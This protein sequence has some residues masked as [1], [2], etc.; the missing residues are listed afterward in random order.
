MI[1]SRNKKHVCEAFMRCS[2]IFSLILLFAIARGGTVNT[3]LAQETVR[4]ISVK[5]ENTSV[6]NALREIN[7]LSGNQVV[8]RTEEVAKETKRVTFESQNTP[9]I[10]V[11][12]KCL[13]GT[14]LN[15]TLREGRIIVV[16]Q[17][18]KD[19]QI[20]G[21]VQ[22]ES[23]QPLPGVTVLL[24]GTTLGTA[25]DTDGKYKLTLPSNTPNPALV[26]SFIGMKTQ[27]IAYSGQNKVNVT[28]AQEASEIDE[29]VVTGIFQK[30]KESYTGAATT[31]TADDLK[32]VGNRNI[33][34]SIRNI[35]PSF[36]IIDNPMM[37]SDPNALPDITIRGNAS[38]TT[39]LNDLQSDSRTTQSAN[40]PLFIMDGFE[41][42][43]ERMMDLDDNQIETI[44]LLKDASATAMY[45]TRGANGVVV[46]TTKQ[47]EE[48]KLRLTYKGGVDL[49][50]PDLSSYNLMNAKE[51]LAYEKAAGVYEYRMG[52]G[53]IDGG[54]TGQ[55]LQDLYNIR[56]LAAE[57]GVDT[58][59]LKYPVR[60]GVGHNHSLRL[61]G[62][63]EEIRYAVG[64]QYKNVAGA[65]K[66]S[67]R[68][69]FNGN[70]FL[71]YKLKN[72]TF[73]NDLQISH[74]K[75]INSPYGT[76]SDYANTNAYYK[77]YD[78]DGSLLQILDDTR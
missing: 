34:T 46:I 15:C 73:Q 61:E 70:V 54:T 59:W 3:A 68:N 43:L 24:K 58:Y 49:E 60:T 32:K 35:D 29:V 20:E 22:D 1:F 71:S 36:N 66:G 5:F 13:E 17:R 56:L 8:F 7:R 51:K 57:R 69:T 30:A 11:V 67:D 14:T 53:T 31:I 72:L 62:G 10:T 52:D 63:R 16:P 76:F 27:E 41:I 38:M 19:I 37:G 47:P 75:S 40:M 48:G 4:T 77:P 50:V 18:L 55:E 9:V 6:L 45:G 12:E 21:I 64:L 26:F 78:D 23:K 44:T 25:T 39:S 33:L 42:S 65:M 74:N 2:R 28:M